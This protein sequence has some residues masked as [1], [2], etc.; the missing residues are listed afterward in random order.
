MS[1]AKF[2]KGPWVVAMNSSFFDIGQKDAFG[3]NGIGERVCI[4]VTADMEENAY[5]IAA[6]PEMYEMLEK[7]HDS[8]AGNG[9][10]GE[11]FYDVKSLLAK[12]RGESC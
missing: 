3:Y 2:T 1:E 9:E 5:L 8:M 4:G 6:A 12:A 10:Y 7:I 11:F